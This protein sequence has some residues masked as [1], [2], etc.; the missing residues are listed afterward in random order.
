MK[1]DVLPVLSS[2][3]VLRMAQQCQVPL[4]P[5]GALGGVRPLRK[6]AAAARGGKACEPPWLGGE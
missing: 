5:T 6:P 1:R 2:E 4:L 3:S